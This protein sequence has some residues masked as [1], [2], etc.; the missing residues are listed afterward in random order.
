MYNKK[1]E[2]DVTLC[3]L[4]PDAYERK[5]TDNIINDI[6]KEGFETTN[7]VQK[8]L[9]VDD[10]CVLYHESKEQPYFIDLLSYMTSGISVFFLVKAKDAVNRFN[11]F[12]G[13]TNPSC[14]VEGTLRRKY[15]LSILKNTIHSSNANRLYFEIRQLYN[16]ECTSDLINFPDY[17]RLKDGTICHTVSEH[18]YETGK[19]IG[20]PKYF[21]V[22]ASERVNGW[23]KRIARC[24]KPCA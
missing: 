13:A 5:I 11:D 23:M 3:V 14:S 9:T 24:L 4:K 15:G 12:V 21:R 16:V 10:V 19:V 2:N 7:F 18:C 22:E 6:Q 20:I 1:V 17:F 8:R